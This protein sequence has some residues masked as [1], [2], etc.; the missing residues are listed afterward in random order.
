MIKE[1]LPTT[2]G[3]QHHNSQDRLVEELYVGVARQCPQC[4][5]EYP[6]D[7]LFCREDGCSLEPLKASKV[8]EPLSDG[9]AR[10]CPKCKV[11][12]E[13]DEVYC[14][15][16]GTLLEALRPNFWNRISKSVLDLFTIQNR[17]LSRGVGVALV[18]VAGVYGVFSWQVSD[19]TAQPKV[20]QTSP[21][22][23]ESPVPSSSHS[24]AAPAPAPAPVLAPVLAPVPVSVPAPESKGGLL[25][26]SAISL[27]APDIAANGC[28]VPVEVDA[29]GIA[30]EQIS[31]YSGSRSNLALR[32]ELLSA[33]TKAY[34]GTRLKMARTG[35]VIVDV[36]THDGRVL[37][38]S[39][40]IN[41]NVGCKPESG[42]GGRPSIKV[43]EKGGLLK[44]LFAQEMYMND[45]INSLSISANNGPMLHATI[46]P[47]IA[48]NPYFAFRTSNGASNFSVTALTSSDKAVSWPA[49]QQT[50]E[51]QVSQALS[52]M[53]VSPEQQMMQVNK[54]VETNQAS[55][56]Q[57]LN[58]G[59]ETP[60]AEIEH[61]KQE[62]EEI[63]P[64][65]E[66]PNDNKDVEVVVTSSVE[67]DDRRSG[68]NGSN[69]K[70]V[71]TRDEES[72]FK[73]LTRSVQR[74]LTRIGYS[75]GPADGVP[76]PRTKQEIRRYQAAENI[77][78]DG[79][80]SQTLLSRLQS[81]RPGHARHAR[82]VDQGGKRLEEIVG[83]FFKKILEKSE[84]SLQDGKPERTQ[85]NPFFSDY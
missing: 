83:G 23:P 40:S 41:V 10:R 9:T 32:A 64:A 30:V 54:H 8:A 42:S 36:V 13:A 46:T 57:Y 48:K 79:L 16:D 53:P 6:A 62:L 80:V 81:E 38:A 82:E 49:A 31:I 5:K 59:K 74:E 65:Q 15:H 1:S 69:T 17:R 27:K 19:E 24:P 55:S 85:Q 45:Y 73:A 56:E 21:K 67:S 84:R 72:P 35:P 18:L 63:K 77:R 66:L 68:I 44:M 20:S 52:E 75:P 34:A 60:V 11:K 58:V 47:W 28:L 39:K 2:G 76:G 26:S 29:P 37:T 7:M 25:L 61:L 33:S 71:A 50:P 70:N 12:Y 51:P 43:R 3:H 78:E 14:R 4:A 22:L